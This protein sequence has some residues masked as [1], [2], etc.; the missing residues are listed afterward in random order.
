MEISNRAN[1]HRALAAGGAV[2][3][4]AA[5]VAGAHGDEAPPNVAR[6]IREIQKEL[7]G[8]VVQGYSELWGAKAEP[9]DGAKP[10][11]AGAVWAS[12]NDG[13]PREATLRVEALREAAAKLDEMANLLEPLELYSQAD[14]LRDQAQ[15]LRLDARELAGASSTPTQAVA[16][17]N[18]APAE[19]Q[20][21][22]G[23][24]PIPRSEE[25]PAPDEFHAPPLFGPN[26]RRGPTPENQL[27]PLPE[28]SELPK[29][30]P[31]SE[32]PR[33]ER[34]ELTPT[35]LSE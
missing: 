21:P 6:E 5:I 33:N 35:P 13:R 22:S 10:Q 14:A 4:S 11:A 24:T 32:Q 16:P 9:R 1:R 20:P 17:M 18:V 8:S 3:L 34:P 26:E 12:D 7:G 27:P 25:R 31:E 2:F 15:R 29:L 19:L 28:R 30:E 23:Y